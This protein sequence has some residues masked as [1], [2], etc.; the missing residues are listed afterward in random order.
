MGVPLA[1]EW[2]KLY[3]SFVEDYY[4]KIPSSILFI[5]RGIFIVRKCYRVIL[6]YIPLLFRTMSLCLNQSLNALLIIA[7]LKAVSVKNRIGT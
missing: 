3:K 1:N 2:A 6:P 7:T 4:D 5:K